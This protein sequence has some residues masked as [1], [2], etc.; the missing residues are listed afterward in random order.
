MEPNPN[1]RN[2]ELSKNVVK[3]FESLDDIIRIRQELAQNEMLIKE[4][5]T[6]V[7]SPQVRREKPIPAVLAFFNFR[8]DF[9]LHS[10]SGAHR[11][12]FK[13]VY[14]KYETIILSGSDSWLV[15]NS[16]VLSIESPSK[17][18]SKGKK[19][20][21][22]KSDNAGI[23]L[24]LTKFYK[25]IDMFVDAV[26]KPIRDD[27]LLSIY[28]IF[29]SLQLSGIEIIKGQESEEQKIVR[30]KRE[31]LIHLCR[32]HQRAKAAS[33]P[34]MPPGGGSIFDMFGQIIKREDMQ[35]AIQSGNIGAM[36][37]AVTGSLNES[38]GQFGI[39][40]K[41]EGP[42][43]GDVANAGETFKDK[44]SALSQDG[45]QPDMTK[46]LGLAVETFGPIA[47]KYMPTNP[48]PV[49]SETSILKPTTTPQA[50]EKQLKETPSSSKDTSSEQKD[51]TS[52]LSAAH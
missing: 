29:L 34:Q 41:I 21:K 20:K 11:K 44:I 23:E 19:G 35:K 14:D 28:R 13:E 5:Q 16:I 7:P 27:F 36:A 9:T 18:E 46:I 45:S 1:N 49:P 42:V 50:G 43:I 48:N 51:S 15:N 22:E 25:T 24:Q 2:N 52:T 4:K 47:T 38:A 12:L 31:T 33:T 3:L 37:Q 30:T 40:E 6:G 8:N 39:K 10:N 17:K 26:A 32:T